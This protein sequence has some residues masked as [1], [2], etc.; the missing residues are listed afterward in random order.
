MINDLQDLLEQLAVQPEAVADAAAAAG[1]SRQRRAS[2]VGTAQYV[3]PEVS[4]G[5][6]QFGVI[7]EKI[8]EFMFHW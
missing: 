6:C 8:G 5:K 1:P 3:S 7:L 2:F 4:G